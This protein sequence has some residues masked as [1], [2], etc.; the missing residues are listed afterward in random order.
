MIST[1]KSGEK[2]RRGGT[3]LPGWWRRAAGAV[4]RVTALLRPGHTC[5]SAVSLSWAVARKSNINTLY[6]DYDDDEWW[7][8]EIMDKKHEWLRT[9]K[10][11]KN[12]EPRIKYQ[13][14]EEKKLYGWTE[15]WILID[16]WSKWDKSVA[17]IFQNIS[18]VHL[19]D[20]IVS[21]SQ[22]RK[23]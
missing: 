9:S 1:G 6:F 22:Q 5:L 11:W 19:I 7:M 10:Y 2:V 21:I 4:R 16:L 8:H 3:A 13:K 18:W 17:I 12:L 15:Q 23:L 20:A 14:E